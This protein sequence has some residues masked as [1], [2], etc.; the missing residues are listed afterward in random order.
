MLMVM[1]PLDDLCDE[2]GGTGIDEVGD[3]C[4]ACDGWGTSE[5][6]VTDEPPDDDA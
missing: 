6:A 5:S 2:C 4:D 1:S 3:V